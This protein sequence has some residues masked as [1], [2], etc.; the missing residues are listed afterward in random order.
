MYTYVH[1]NLYIKVL[2]VWYN[3][4]QKF[5]LKFTNIFFVPPFHN[6]LKCRKNS[7]SARQCTV[8]LKAKINVFWKFFEWRVSERGPRPGVKKKIKK[9]LIFA[10]ELSNRA[11]T[12]THISNWIFFCDLAHSVL[13][14]IGRKDFR[15]RFRP[16]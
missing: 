14:A 2:D 6:E 7:I 1:C 5:L 13:D 11:T 3:T 15:H 16:F 8:C 9:I 12:Q 10:F 4:F